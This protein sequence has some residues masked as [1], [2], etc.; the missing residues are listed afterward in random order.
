MLVYHN[1]HEELLMLNGKD[2]TH[3]YFMNILKYRYIMNSL[4]HQ[5][6]N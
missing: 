1:N 2:M 4:T 5:K 3:F 6:L